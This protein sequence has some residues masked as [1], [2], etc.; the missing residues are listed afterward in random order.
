MKHVLKLLGLLLLLMVAQQGSLVHE[1]G[2]FSRAGNAQQQVKSVAATDASCALCSAFAQV[3]T[4]AFSHS[5][6]IPS[7]VRVAAEQ[8]AAVLF[9]VADAAVPASR[10]RGPPSVS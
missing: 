1:F 8:Q 7:L 9:S 6:Q 2:H 4:P 3:V 10:S 5:F